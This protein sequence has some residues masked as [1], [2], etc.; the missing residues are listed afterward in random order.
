MRSCLKILV[1]AW[2]TP[3]AAAG[4]SA[5]ATMLHFVSAFGGQNGK[6]LLS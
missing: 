4:F 2:T 5:S 1:T 3:E 6:H